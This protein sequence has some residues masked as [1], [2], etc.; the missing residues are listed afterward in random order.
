MSRSS[1]SAG[2]RRTIGALL[3]LHASLSVARAQVIRGRLVSADSSRP[4]AGVI[5][6]LR[7]SSNADV[8]R[9][10]S[11]ADGSFVVR[12]AAPGFYRMRTL[13]IGF[14]PG[15]YGPYRMGASD[16]VQLLL[17]LLDTPIEIGRA[18]CR[19]RV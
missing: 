3:L 17:P 11:G 8:A 1:R 7:D 2:A 18:S 10:L 13:R 6:V 16:D 19:E 4:V 5:V 15:E 9:V 12:L 14:R